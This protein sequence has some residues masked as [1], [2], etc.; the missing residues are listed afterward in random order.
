[1]KLIVENSPKISADIPYHPDNRELGSRRVEADGELYISGGDFEEMK[2]GDIL[3]LKYLMNLRI[4]EKT[5]EYVRAEFLSREPMKNVKIIQWVP[6]NEA[7]RVKVLVPDIIYLNDE[8]NPN[9]LRIVDGFGERAIKDV[10]VD[11]IV[12]FERFGFCR[13][14]SESEFIF[15]KAHD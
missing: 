2:V 5:D 9:S 15:I 7:V 8:I 4:I 12:Q 11:E 1:V 13:R 14:D 3:R 10:E 6:A